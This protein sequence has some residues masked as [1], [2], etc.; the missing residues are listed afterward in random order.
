[1]GSLYAPRY[2]VPRGVTRRRSRERER[3]GADVGDRFDAGHCWPHEKDGGG[4][5]GGSHI[6]SLKCVMKQLEKDWQDASFL[7]AKPDCRSFGGGREG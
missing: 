2:P 6:R 4:E 5:S 3:E 7:V 1:M